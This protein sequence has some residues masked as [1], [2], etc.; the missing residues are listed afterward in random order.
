MDSEDRSDKKRKRDVSDS[1]K[2]TKKPRA[3]EYE[4]IDDEN[5]VDFAQCHAQLAALDNAVASAS[6]QTIP[7]S[8]PVPL[9]PT[10][11]PSTISELDRL[12]FEIIRL[13]DREME[14]WENPRI[15]EMRLV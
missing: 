14:W 1:D 10:V 8:V 3:N 2:S 7:S 4:T 13:P 6:A 12:P 9:S 11:V 5:S 15:P